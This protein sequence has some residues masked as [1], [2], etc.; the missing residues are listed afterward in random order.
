M[1]HSF[2]DGRV[3][4]SDS[5]TSFTQSHSRSMSHGGSQSFLPHDLAGPALRPLDF[6]ALMQSHDTTHAEL[7]HTVDELA[8]WLAVV[9]VGLTH[10]LDRSTQDTIEEEQ[11]LDGPEDD[12]SVSAYAHAAL[13]AGDPP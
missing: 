13:V 8:Q 7:A 2:S 11:E 4:T 12:V 10:M 6:G 5:S 1:N 3:G 9:E